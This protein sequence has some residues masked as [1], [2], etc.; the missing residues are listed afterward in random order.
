MPLFYATITTLLTG[1]LC[2]TGIAKSNLKLNLN[3]AFILFNFLEV[4]VLCAGEC[5]WIG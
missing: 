4:V 1:Y 5:R 3:S 2:N